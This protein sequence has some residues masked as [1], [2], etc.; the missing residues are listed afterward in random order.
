MGLRAGWKKLMTGFVVAAAAVLGH[1]AWRAY[2]HAD[3]WLQVKDH[4]G[5][6]SRVLW[7]DV[8]EA[9]VVLR[10]A[11][12]RVLA[13]ASLTPPYGQTRYTGPAGA[14]DCSALERQGGAAW[15]DCFESQSRWLARWA[16]HVHHARVSVGR[17]AID[18]APVH[19]RRFGDWWLWWVPLPHMGGS[20][21][22]RYVLAIHIDSARCVITQPPY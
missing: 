15:R 4:A 7:V 6:T 8:N 13:E 2:T 16:P 11:A 1:G 17:C 18:R 14:V 5:R 22:N 9:Q 12:D 20:P 19:G 3:V 21:V 10:D